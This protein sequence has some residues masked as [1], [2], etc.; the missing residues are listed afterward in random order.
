MTGL[1]A[2]VR[3]PL[4]GL[5]TRA[6]HALRARVAGADAPARAQRIWGTPGE[7]W[8]TPQDPVWRVHA[9]AAMF[10]GGLTAL[11]LQSLH[12]LAMAGVADHSGFK[13]DPWG[14]LHRTSEY[15][16]TTTF[17]RVG[18][19][20][21]LIRKVRVVH[22]RV[23]GTAPDGRPYRAGD[24]HLLLW[25]HVAETWSFLRA[26]E[27]FGD[28]T[29]T[30]LEADGYVRQAGEI[31]QRLGVRVPPGTVAE[32]D[33]A[34]TRFRS[35][36][37]ATPAALETSRFLLVHPPLPWLS[38]P[39]FWALA[40]GSLSLLPRWAADELRLPGPDA[41]RVRLGGPVGAGS[42]AAVRWVMGGLEE[43]RPLQSQHRRDLR[44]P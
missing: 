16:A 39:A 13:G 19:A 7:R 37:R 38:R 32:L 35:E 36:L 1:A 33:Q 15:L 24:P 12:P 23:K 34:L 29:L 18:D 10:P 22:G 31:A 28:S 5:R 20:E 40:A 17:G 44:A 9:D 6:G 3:R 14:R 25:V 21:E 30:P 2:V 42:T 4:Q 27:R 8:F 26:Y 11:L 43:R 41:V